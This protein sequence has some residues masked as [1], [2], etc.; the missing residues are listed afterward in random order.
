MSVVSLTWWWIEVVLVFL[1]LMV[2]MREPGKGWSKIT[3]P[4]SHGAPISS[5]RSTDLLS[6]LE[7]VNC[8]CCHVDNTHGVIHQDRCLGAICFLCWCQVFM[9]SKREIHDRPL[10]WMFHKHEQGTIWLEIQ[11]WNTVKFIFSYIIFHIEFW[12]VFAYYNQ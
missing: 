1:C 4:S 12:S 8:L 9:F 6:K 3:L 5:T 10:P 7:P 2:P 11:W